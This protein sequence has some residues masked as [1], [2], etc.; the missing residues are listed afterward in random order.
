MSEWLLRYEGYDPAEEPLRESLCTLGNG[1]FATRGAAPEC[2]AGGAH[3]PGTYAAGVFNRLT[4]EM[5]G[6]EV[7]NESIVNLPDWTS[8]TFRTAEDDGWFSIDTAQVTAYIKE[9][10]MRRGILTRTFTVTD[11]QGRRTHVRQRRVVS[12]ADPYLAGLETTFEAENWSGPLVVRSGIDGRVANTGVKRYVG[13]GDQHLRPAEIERVGDD[14]VLLTTRTVQSGVRVAV[15]VRHH[16]VVDEQHRSTELTPVT[17]GDFVGH[18]IT[19]RL[20]P[21]QRVGVEKLA[22]LYTGHDPAISDPSGEARDKVECAPDFASLAERHVVSWKH[23]W[24]RFDLSIHGDQHTAMV[25]HLHLFHLM[26]TLSPHTAELDVGVPARGLHGEAYRGHIFWDELFVLR[27]LNF[28]FPELSRSLLMYRWRRLPQARKAAYDAGCLGAMYPWQSGSNGREES[29]QLHLNPRSGRWLIDR[30]HLQRHIGSAI[31]Y[32]VWRYYEASGDLEWLAD[33]GAEMLLEIAR[34]WGSLA[35]YDPDTDRF[36]IRGVMGPDEYHD[37]YPW[38]DRGGLDNN[39]YTNVMAAWVIG[40]ALDV[41]ELLPEER[42]TRLLGILGVQDEDLAHL[43]RV[44]RRLRLVWHDGGIPSQFEGYD[45]LEEFDWEGYERKY[46]DIT[47]LDRI[48]E[49]EGDTTN[50][51]R[52]SKQADVL[53]LFFL[54]SAGELKTTL[55]RMGYPYDEDLIPRTIDYYSARTAHGSTLSKVVH[56]WVLAR[57]DRPR[58]W[59]Y[60]CE[61]LDSD[62]GDVQGGT[63]A[64]GIHLGAMAGTVD[65]LQRGF[66]KLSAHVDGL[67]IDPVLPDEL[68]D[69][70]FTFRHR[71][72]WQ[73][74]VRVTHDRLEL[75]CPPD[76]GPMEI[77]FDSVVN[78]IPPGQRLELPLHRPR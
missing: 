17:D 64:E 29:A 62:I 33:Y 22:A 49:A 42:R 7:E 58:A 11:D 38:S 43:D 76:A 54:L 5:D 47:R 8:L 28:R 68:E 31:A 35:T 59:R 77:H 18:E 66:T 10:D 32:N 20:E 53:M 63:T 48:L 61:A 44:S 40:R 52:L 78:R 12:M 50:R 57:L 46:G 19:L 30:S 14:A 75:G 70:E 37:G 65:L 34:F 26:Q 25:L 45:K 39:A 15:A 3:Y 60:F 24:D 1:R 74:R 73:A 4:A 36:D 9:L 56:S 51:Y 16:V 55:E 21:G 27:L 71:E 23:L 67:Y 72:H 41:V 13:L 6:H 2:R 69:L